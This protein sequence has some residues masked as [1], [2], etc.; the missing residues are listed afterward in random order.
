MIRYIT[1]A[2]FPAISYRMADPY[3]LCYVIQGPY[4]TVFCEAVPRVEFVEVLW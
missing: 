4:P 3:D 1:L 2:V